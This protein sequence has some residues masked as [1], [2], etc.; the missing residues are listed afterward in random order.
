LEL[1]IFLEIAEKISCD[2]W[3]KWADK[4]EKKRKGNGKKWPFENA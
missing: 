1:N 2:G 3:I 4:Q